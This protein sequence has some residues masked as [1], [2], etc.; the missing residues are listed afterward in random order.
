MLFLTL[1]PKKPSELDRLSAINALLVRYHSPGCGHCV[2][3]KEEWASL[4]NHKKLKDKDITIMDVE[5]SLT[6][7]IKHK[8][9]R[10]PETQGVPTIVFIQGDKV[11]EHTGAREADAMADF[12]LEQMGQSGGRRKRTKT[13][14]RGSKSRRR[15]IKTKRR[16][17]L[18]KRKTV[19]RKNKRKS[20]KK[21]GKMKKRKTRSKKGG[22]VS[23]II[24]IVEN[25]QHNID[26]FRNSNLPD[27]G[28]GL[29][30]LIREM[31][32]PP[33]PL[34][35]QDGFF[36]IEWNANN[37]PHPMF[38]RY[39]PAFD[40]RDLN[41]ILEQDPE[42]NNVTQ[43]VGGPRDPVENEEDVIDWDEDV[44]DSDDDF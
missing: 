23:K 1:D 25:T 9:A 4:K 43:F 35:L 24:W 13:K 36:I 27:N 2:A 12:A 21:R 14:R 19:K 40:D 22:I 5:S 15:G 18:K 8:S 38:N 31:E 33:P 28:I 39:H 26:R 44:I 37:E 16:R 34:P 11:K 29:M 3:M 6:P 41:V 42:L 7:Q 10:L 32:N 20:T 17:N 30:K